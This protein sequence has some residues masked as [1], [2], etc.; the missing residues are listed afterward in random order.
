M[1][2]AK[3]RV[4]FNDNIAIDLRRV[5]RAAGWAMFNAVILGF[6]NLRLKRRLGR[7]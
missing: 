5:E 7:Y 1:D 4:Q 6:H 2:R 3:R